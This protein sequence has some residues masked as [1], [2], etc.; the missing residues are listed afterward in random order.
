MTILIGFIVGIAFSLVCY[1][2]TGN[3]I[4]TI[5]IGVI[6]LCYFVFFAYKV[7]KNKDE[8]IARFQDCYHFVNNFL[9]SLSIKGH[10]SGALA[11]AL[12][13]QNEETRELINS[14]DT[15][16]PMQK[17]KYLKK[18]FKFD[19]YYLFV[20]LIVLYN[21]EGGDILQMS[22]YLLNQIRE[23]EEYLVNAERLNKSALVEF[24]ALWIFSLAILA[25]LKFS[26]D[27]FF[28]YIVKNNFYQIS[29]VCVLLFALYS[30]HLA[31][32]KVTRID[33]KGWI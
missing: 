29:V 20:D 23:S 2:S 32:K 1:V 5:F 33:I 17:V 21:E 7:I 13:S 8:K 30:V 4:S 19:V 10:V 6:T 11:S 31:V 22:S 18:H 12:E 24:A 25:I 27:D 16:D 15:D 9:I 3:Y 26:L 14:L 28:T